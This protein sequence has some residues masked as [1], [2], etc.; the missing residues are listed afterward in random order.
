MDV[1]LIVVLGTLDLKS[2]LGSPI[3]IQI[4]RDSS[5]NIPEMFLGSETPAAPV[6]TDPAACRALLAPGEQPE[7]SH[8][9][10]VTW[11]QNQ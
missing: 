8:P 1:F 5:G 4:G 2:I 11:D 10:Q 7:V 9:G 6:R 3:A